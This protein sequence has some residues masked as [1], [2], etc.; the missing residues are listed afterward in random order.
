VDISPPDSPVGLRAPGQD[1]P[2][3][4]PIDETPKQVF[5]ATQKKSRFESQIPILRK[6][7][8]FSSSQPPAGQ[9]SKQGPSLLGAGKERFQAGKKLL[10]GRDQSNKDTKDENL[11]PPEPWKGANGRSALVNLVESKQ[12]AS[13]FIPPERESV[14]R[15]PSPFEHLD[16]TRQHG[17]TV[18]TISTG[19]AAEREADRKRIANKKNG[20][21]S[22]PA[23]KGSSTQS[24][25]TGTAE[26]A[27]IRQTTV[28]QVDPVEAGLTSRFPGLNV[29][30]EPG[31]RFSATTYAPTE[32]GRS[33]A[34]SIRA[35][36]DADA[37]PVPSLS[38]SIMERKRP[39]TSATTSAKSTIRKAISSPTDVTSKSL[40]QGP[41]E[42]QVQ[43]RI[44][45][46]EAR[47]KELAVRKANI[48][49]I[50][51]ELTQVIQ[52]SSVAYDMATRDEVKRTVTSLN[53][54]LDDIKREE[55]DIGVKLIRAWKK[56]DELDEYEPT[57]LWVKRVTS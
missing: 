6:E 16:F 21:P 34:G 54:E 41:P 14:T 29:A 30:E 10:R 36:P 17:Y 57:G 7:N 45:S 56:R 37:P 19:T 46:L 49:T 23:A 9:P 5:H 39:I 40:P 27:Q 28:R 15:T 26:N 22:Q 25:T 18:T 32:A 50:I 24:G 3:I 52:P 48:N 12:D 35:E 33:P 44:K 51:Y 43:S 31:S 42:I 11:V 2:D 20:N 13:T 1:S 47:Q 53:N 8:R 55:H 38:A 4:S